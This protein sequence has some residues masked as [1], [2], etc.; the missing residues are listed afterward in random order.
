MTILENHSLAKYSTF[1]VGGPADFFA[2]PNNIVELQELVDFS[3]SKNIP[4]TILGGG[5][6]ILISD[7][8][9]RGLVL[10]LSGEFKNIHNNNNNNKIVTGAATS[11]PK[12]SKLALNQACA[13]ALGWAGTPGSVGGALIMNAGSIHG[14]I[15]EVVESVRILDL[16]TNQIKTL[17]HNQISFSYRNT[18]FPDNLN[19]IIILDA[20]LNLSLNPKSRD[21]LSPENLKLKAKN[22]V[23]RRKNTQPKGKTAGS[24]FK[25]PTNPSNTFAAQLIQ[26][27]NLKGYEI[28]GAKI[29]EL[30]ANFILNFNNAKAQDI[31]DLAKHAQQTVLD[32]FGVKLIFEVKLLGEF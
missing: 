1:K 15:G 12:L 19:H 13:S 23:M 24:I 20:K 16:A 26:D 30:H 32:K 5:S 14:E 4:I 28:N 31:Y 18:K 25:N 3:K 7:A 6:N 8:G 2:E 22:L 27:A 17:T 11:F 9:I 10:I 21:S 29:S